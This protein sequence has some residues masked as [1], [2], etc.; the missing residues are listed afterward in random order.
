MKK[1]LKKIEKDLSLMA[2]T[3]YFK[4]LKN[5]CSLDIK[6]LEKCNR[7]FVL[8]MDIDIDRNGRII[9]KEENKSG[10]IDNKFRL[11]AVRYLHKKYPDKIFL[12]V[13]GCNK[14]LRKFRTEA[15]KDYL[16]KRK[17]PDRNLKELRCCPGNT[18]GNVIEIIKYIKCFEK[19]SQKQT[20]F[21][22][23]TNLYHLPRVEGLLEIMA[24]KKNMEVLKDREKRREIFKFIP[25]EK[26]IV[27]TG[28]KIDR[29]II[30]FY[31]TEKI[32]KRILNEING[33][34]QIKN[35]TYS[36]S[37]PSETI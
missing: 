1:L 27:K 3:D 25:V 16:I 7:I 26:I 4:E 17:I 21:G 29:N 28:G 8:S 35:K 15:M 33:V 12:I 30:N 34:W 23:L 36:C 24:D 18:C 22:L 32:G 11:R 13:G 14:T 31:K 6:E 5:Y 37:W 9:F 10:V 20:S 19:I 2:Y